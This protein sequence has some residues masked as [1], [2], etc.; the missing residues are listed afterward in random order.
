MT[1]KGTVIVA[2]GLAALSGAIVGAT[3]ILIFIWLL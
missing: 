1:N 2:M 3:A